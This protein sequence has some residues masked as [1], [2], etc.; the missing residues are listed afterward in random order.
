MKLDC[1][2]HLDHCYIARH[3]NGCSMLSI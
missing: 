3:A 2:L 1:K